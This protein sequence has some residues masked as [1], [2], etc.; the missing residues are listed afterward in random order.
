MTWFSSASLPHRS[1][2]FQRQQRPPVRQTHRHTTRPHDLPQHHSGFAVPQPVPALNERDGSCRS[3]H[4]THGGAR[5][6]LKGLQALG[7]PGNA[8]AQLFLKG[9]QVA[10]PDRLALRFGQ[11]RRHRLDLKP[12]AFDLRSKAPI[13]PKLHNDGD[14]PKY[15]VEASSPIAEIIE[16]H[17]SIVVDDLARMIKQQE[18]EIPPRGSVEFSNETGYHLMLYETDKIKAGDKV[19]FTLRFKDGSSLDTVYEVLDRR[20]R[21]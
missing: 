8:R 16:I 5:A 4:Y 6:C 18:V 21:F 19:P 10:R 17:R 20:E 15:L 7:I 1:V 12:P 14:S 3:T 9:R 2:A 11:G 13:R